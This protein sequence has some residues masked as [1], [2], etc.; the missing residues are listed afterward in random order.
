M[1]NVYIEEYYGDDELLPEIIIE[2]TTLPVSVV[3]RFPPQVA[4]DWVNYLKHCT[5]VLGSGWK[6]M[7]GCVFFEQQGDISIWDFYDQH[8]IKLHLT[9]ELKQEL[10][11]ALLNLRPKYD[12]IKWKDKQ[13]PS[14]SNIESE[15][16]GD[17]G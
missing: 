13:N 2:W 14:P 17:A 12:L 11:D 7:D 9:P 3:L 5:E 10:C 15:E 1:F 8:S 6:D 16:E 4:F